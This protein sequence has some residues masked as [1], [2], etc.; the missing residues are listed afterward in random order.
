MTTD[1]L[2]QQTGDRIPAHTVLDRLIEML[3]PTGSPL[4]EERRE[5]W[6]RVARATVDY[7][8]PDEDGAASDGEGSEN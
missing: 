1:I 4:S 6:M 2:A 5:S 8:Y 7:L 3:P